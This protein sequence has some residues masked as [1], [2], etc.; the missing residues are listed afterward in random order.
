M[1]H[2]EEGNSRTEKYL[3][4]AI[5]GEGVVSLFFALYLG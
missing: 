1:F 2:K 3:C 5:Q 4:V